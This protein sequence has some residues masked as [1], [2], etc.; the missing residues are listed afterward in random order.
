MDIAGR[1]RMVRGNLSQVKFAE[2]IGLSQRTIANYENGDNIPNA[3][4]VT[5]ISDIFGVS[6]DWL[7]KGQGAIHPELA[8]SEQSDK[9]EDGDAA[10]RFQC[11]RCRK[12][13]AEL[14]AERREARLQTAELREVN[15]ENRRLWQ[16][17]AGLRERLA[18][19]EPRGQEPL[20]SGDP[21]IP[22]LSDR[23]G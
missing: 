14:W 16:E 18:R 6:L 12:L 11:P 23:R 15:A 19:L 10:I 17:N 20:N 21:P 8:S 7:L 2:K 3:E 1:I 22:S 13:S 5:R 4:V 9:D